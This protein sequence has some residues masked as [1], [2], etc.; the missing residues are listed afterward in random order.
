MAAILEHRS[1]LG[2]TITSRG[3]RHLAE[4][5]DLHR[6]VVLRDSHLETAELDVLS[7]A[8]TRHRIGPHDPVALPTPFAQPR[9]TWR[10]ELS[11]VQRPPVIGVAGLVGPG[12]PRAHTRWIDSADAYDLL[13]RSTQRLADDLRALHVH[14]ADGG[15]TVFQT[16][17]PLVTTDPTTGRRALF[18]GDAVR[19]VLGVG[20]RDSRA[21][22][23]HLDD[24]LAHIDPVVVPWKRGDTVVWDG[25]S[26]LHDAIDLGAHG[27]VHVACFAGTVP[28]GVDGRP[29]RVRHAPP[30]AAISL[31]S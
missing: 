21:L 2:R 10:N 6:V 11:F 29:S 17:H 30:E 26:A 12:H 25:R 20:D 22:L 23:A 16:I 8:L 1:V 14:V 27:L 13:P 4:Q 9:G 5:L 15:S 24:H 3:V 7:Q 31:A 28:I 18:V 19:R